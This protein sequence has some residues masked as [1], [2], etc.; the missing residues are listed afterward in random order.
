MAPHRG[1]AHLVGPGCGRHIVRH[2]KVSW[3]VR[4]AV[5]KIGETGR[6][7][8]GLEKRDDRG[9][10]RHDHYELE[11]VDIKPETKGFA[12]GTAIDLTRIA[13]SNGGGVVGKNMADSDGPRLRLVRQVLVQGL[14]F[15]ARPPSAKTNYSAT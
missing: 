7:Q 10:L 6:G 8:R 13:N 5:G 4:H 2:G 14:E 11:A 1:G 15:A 12:I 9:K 3:D